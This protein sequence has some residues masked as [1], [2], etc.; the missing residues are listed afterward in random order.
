LN[1]RI[2]DLEA[3]RYIAKIKTFWTQSVNRDYTFRIYSPFAIEIKDNGS[4]KSED[5]F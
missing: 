2:L 4:F 5:A 3:G 1:L